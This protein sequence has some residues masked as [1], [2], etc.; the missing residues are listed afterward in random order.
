M[1]YLTCVDNDDGWIVGLSGKVGL[2]EML[3]WQRS[4]RSLNDTISQGLQTISHDVHFSKDFRHGQF[5]PLGAPS[6]FES[7]TFQHK[8]GKSAESLGRI[9]FT[10]GYG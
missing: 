5:L 1:N 6:S 7:G 9:Y 3:I 4:P 2:Q 8:V 10:G